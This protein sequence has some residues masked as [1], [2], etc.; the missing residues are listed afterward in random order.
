[1][2][3]A[4]NGLSVRLDKWLWAA[5]FYKSRA[6]ARAQI[7][8]GKVHYNGQRVKPSKSVEL[9]A[10]VRCWQGS[11]Q[12]EVRV[13]ALSEVRQSAPLAQWLYAETPASVQQRAQNSV[14]RQL[15]SQFA[16]SPERRPAKH[17]RRKLVQIKQAPSHDS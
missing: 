12:R 2:P 14:A 16:P 6:L 13:L 1:M 11:D 9:G 4:A 3:S 7:E 17:E 15:G 8:G 10:V 5:R